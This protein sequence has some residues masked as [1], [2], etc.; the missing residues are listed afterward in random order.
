MPTRTAILIAAGAVMLSGCESRARNE[1]AAATQAVPAAGNA[2]VEKGLAINTPAFEGRLNI[3]GMTIGGEDMDLDG[4]KLPP[5]SKVT[6][7]KV[8]APDAGRDQ[9]RIAFTSDT[10]AAA[11]AEH[12]RAQGREAGYALVAGTTD[13]L[14]VRGAKT[15]GESFALTVA[16]AGAGATGT[17]LLLDKD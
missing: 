12:F 8:D 11:V 14:D 4:M 3:P 2:P 13:P 16:P 10:A 7:I 15:D 6:G 5:G 1:G 9:V 17:L